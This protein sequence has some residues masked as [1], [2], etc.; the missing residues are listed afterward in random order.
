MAR[1]QE[2]EELKDRYKPSQA[3]SEKHYCSFRQSVTRC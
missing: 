2:H 3:R 1:E